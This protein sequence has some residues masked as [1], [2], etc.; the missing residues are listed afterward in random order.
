[1]LPSGGV[2]TSQSSISIHVNKPP[3]PGKFSVRPIPA[4]DKYYLSLERWVDVDLPLSYEY[5]IISASSQYVPIRS[6]SELSYAISLLPVGLDDSSL[7][8][9]C[10]GVIYDFL[11]ANSTSNRHERCL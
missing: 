5:G 4:D 7:E 11:L 9:D 8:L 10:V 6:R 1:M 2:L 3:S